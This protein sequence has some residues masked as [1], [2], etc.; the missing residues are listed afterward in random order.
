MA[1]S[2]RLV[3]IAGVSWFDIGKRLAEQV[4]KKSKLAYNFDRSAYT[5]DPDILTLWREKLAVHS[6]LSMR[7]MTPNAFDLCEGFDTVFS[8]LGEGYSVW[9]LLTLYEVDMFLHEFH[10]KCHYCKNRIME[11]PRYI[12]VKCGDAPAAS[13]KRSSSKGVPFESAC[14]GCYKSHTACDSCTTPYESTNALHETKGVGIANKSGCT[15][16]GYSKPSKAFLGQTLEMATDTYNYGRFDTI[17]RLKNE[18][19]DISVLVYDVGCILSP[20]GLNSNKLGLCV[21]NLYNSDYA[22]PPYDKHELR[23]PMAALQWEVLLAGNS[24]VP[25][26]LVYLKNQ[27]KTFTSASFI[28]SDSNKN[29]STVIELS[30]NT[31]WIPN[32]EEIPA[33][34]IQASDDGRWVVR[35]N[36]CLLGSQ[37]HSGESLPPSISSVNRQRDLA[38]SASHCAIEPTVEWAKHA[39]STPTIQT[40][41]CLGTIVMEPEHLRMHVRFRVGT[42]ISATL[43][44]GGIWEV[45]EI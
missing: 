26:A 19:S 45:F 8:T 39:L 29:E 35:A 11:A 36:N 6:K 5:D 24:T 3:E 28:L 38:E 18:T 14:A 20:F 37:L 13:P 21:F 2:R 22:L 40:D 17:Y 16:F 41:Y 30:A 7:Q 25:Q 33:A 27:V 42:R 43:K 4:G 10:Y 31:K 9:E 1:P 34:F 15:G 23:V 44:N 12:C 32:D